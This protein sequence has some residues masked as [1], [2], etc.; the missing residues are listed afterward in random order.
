MEKIGL[1][2][3]ECGFEF[4]LEQ[5]AN[6]IIFFV[7]IFDVSV[8]DTAHKSGNTTGTILFEQEMKMIG[9][10]AVTE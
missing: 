10:Q 9:H 8:G 3:D 4:T 7:E 5:T 1:G 2:F 6:T